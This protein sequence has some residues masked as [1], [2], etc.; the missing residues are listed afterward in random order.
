[1]ALTVE[2]LGH[3]CFRL[4]G[5]DT[6]AVLIDPFDG[7]IGLKVPKYDC[8]VLLLTH[9]HYDTSA[10][11]LVKSG[12]ELVNKKGPTLS[13][14]IAFNGFPWWHDTRKGKDYGSVITYR[15]EIGGFNVGY[16]SHIGAVPPRWFSEEMTG[17]DLC[18]IPCGGHLTIGASDATFIVKELKPKLVF[19]MH[20]AL[21]HLSFT[22]QPGSEF[23]A[24][25]QEKEYIR[26]YKYIIE[27]DDLPK[28][29][30]QVLMQHW[31]DVQV[32]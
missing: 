1:M 15:F 26:D 12:Y 19:P 18:F 20:I 29:P 31:P 2:W 4:Q 8:D 5:D 9:H 32:F 25:M 10:S 16:L 3:C 11:H 13:G 17:L 24:R 7:K 6:A 14:G 21:P 30:T 23:A 22:L 27:K 28:S